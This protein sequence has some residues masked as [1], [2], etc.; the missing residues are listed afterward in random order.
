MPHLL[1]LKVYG[2]LY[3]SN[4]S[5]FITHKNQGAGAYNPSGTLIG[6]NFL[7]QLFV[8][9]HTSGY[10]SVAY[11]ESSFEVVRFPS[12]DEGGFV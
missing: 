5:Q 7:I 10:G 8:R 6:V 11:L 4:P 12:K 2:F 3:E 9:S 1:A